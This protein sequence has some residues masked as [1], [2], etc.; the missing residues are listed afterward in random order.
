MNIK[1]KILMAVSIISFVASWIIIILSIFLGTIYK[2]LLTNQ[3]S[4]AIIKTTK[5]KTIPK[6]ERNMNYEVRY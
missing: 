6:T 1:E 5:G 3:K 4:C 2:K